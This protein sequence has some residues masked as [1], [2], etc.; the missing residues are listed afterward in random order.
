MNTDKQQLQ[1]TVELMFRSC[2]YDIYDTIIALNKLSLK[3]KI[4]KSINEYMIFYLGYHCKEVTEEKSKSKFNGILKLKKY[5][6]N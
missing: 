5:N 1:T 3:L 4:P 2:S 6:L